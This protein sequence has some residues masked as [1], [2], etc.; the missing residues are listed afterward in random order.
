MPLPERLPRW[1]KLINPLVVRLSRWG[2]A[3]GTMHVLTVRGRKTG[4]PYSMPVSLVTLDGQ[5]YIVSLPWVSWVKNAR[6]SGEGV[7]ER[8]PRTEAVRLVELSLEER[9]PVVRAFPVQVPRGAAFFHLPPD[10]DAFERAA[11][12]LTAFRV[13]SV[14]GDGAGGRDRRGPGDPH[15]ATAP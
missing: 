4:K 9:A 6:A 3:V 14:G 15:G 11:P 7:L 13:E 12:H 8:G 10:P 5:R 1:L 2:L